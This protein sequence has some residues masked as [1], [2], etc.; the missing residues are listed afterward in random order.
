MPIISG[1][2]STSLLP[3]NAG[4]VPF[5]RS[6]EYS[7]VR[8]LLW[9]HIAQVFS[10]VYLFGSE[11]GK[12][13]SNWTELRNFLNSR[14]AFLLQYLS[15]RVVLTIP[16]YL[17]IDAEDRTAAV[18]LADRIIAL[19]RRLLTATFKDTFT[20]TTENISTN[21]SST[22]H[23]FEQNTSHNVAATHKSSNQK[24]SGDLAECWHEY[25]D[26]KNQIDKDYKI[27]FSQKFQCL[28]NNSR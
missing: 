13:P 22:K 8:N 24:F 16:H 3:R 25:I 12:F 1:E 14:G 10:S 20:A 15:R 2:V 4:F 19:G 9:K 5:V 21:N 27:F 18:E 26:H 23:I 28:H 6:I 17:F 11:L 7:Y